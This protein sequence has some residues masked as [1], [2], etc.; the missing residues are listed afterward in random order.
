MQKFILGV[1]QIQ[2]TLLK[3]HFLITKNLNKRK[4]VKIPE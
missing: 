4:I 2:K 1:A 3:T